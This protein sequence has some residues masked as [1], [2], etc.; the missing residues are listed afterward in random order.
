[1]R[2][3]DLEIFRAVHETSSFQRAAQRSGLSQSAVTKI[4][5]KLED[6][7]GMALM[8]RGAGVIA[9]T[10][11]GRTLYER[12]IEL[13]DLAAATRRDMVSEAAALRGSVRLGVVPALLHSVATPVLSEVLAKSKA[14]QI[15]LTVKH[16]A[17]LVRL[18][19]DGKL[20]LA[21]CFGV[22]H[23]A[24]NVACALVGHQRYQLVVRAGHPL[25]AR[26]PSLQQLSQMG[27]LLPPSGVTLRAEIERMFSDAELGPLNVRIE[28]DASATLLTPFI[29]Q[30]NLIGVLA[31]QALHPLSKEGLGALDVDLPALLGNV[32]IYYRRRAPSVGVVMD[33][34]H[35]LEAQARSNLPA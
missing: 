34:R 23:V 19:E 16:S 30:G 26:R 31:E 35:R 11:A 29:L 15:Q 3:E 27:W 13:A 20:D 7:F 5:R 2:L 12:A 25:L 22:Q 24:P 1:M 33:I 9:L 6:E 28:S 18:V 8:E 4:V 10:P 32:V 14:A 17:E 21:L